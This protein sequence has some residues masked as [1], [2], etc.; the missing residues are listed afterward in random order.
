MELKGSLPCSQELAPFLIII[1]KI[2]LPAAAYLV[3][4]LHL[5]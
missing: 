1:L 2:W 4:V 3:Y 5:Y